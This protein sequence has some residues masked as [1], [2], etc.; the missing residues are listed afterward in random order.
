MGGNAVCPGKS[1]NLVVL[2][3][4]LQLINFHADLLNAGGILQPYGPLVPMIC[5]E[6]ANAVAIPV[7][8]NALTNPLYAGRMQSNVITGKHTLAC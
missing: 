3:G 6:R 5:I 8:I 1:T 7:Q 2:D 4:W